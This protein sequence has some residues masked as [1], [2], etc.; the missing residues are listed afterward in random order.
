MKF[1]KRK[2][3][4]KGAAL[5]MALGVLSLVSLLAFSAVT[6]SRY[7]EIDA[8]TSAGMIRSCYIAEGFANRLYWLILND[9]KKYP[10]RNINV[11][12]DSMPEIENRYWADGT[13]R[14]VKDYYGETV[15]YEIR[16]AVC[17]IDISGALP[18]RELLSMAELHKKDSEERRKLDMI[19]NRLQDYVDSDNLVKLHSMEK[20]EYLQANLYNL[21]RNRPFQYREEAL[22]IPGIQEFLPVDNSGRLTAVRL[23]APPGMQA[24]GGRPNL[25]SC[26]VAQ[27]A[28]RC[29][30]TELETAELNHAM[31]AW[32][33][34][35]TALQQSLPSGFLQ[36]LEMYFNTSESGYYTVLIDTSSEQ[37]PGIRAAISF[38][39]Q[40]NSVSQVEYYEYMFY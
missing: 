28:S 29:R 39:L 35:R 23:I 32:K 38:R 10:Q 22:L 19:G 12:D 14:S 24:I 17:G 1:F 11:R 2:N 5:I 3:S 27:I 13:I 4:E 21:P 16:D 34:N 30:L 26:S 36:R 37:Q 7:A 9:R 6:L 15:Q 25:Y 40:F 8:H 33:T 18:H 31:T 20:K